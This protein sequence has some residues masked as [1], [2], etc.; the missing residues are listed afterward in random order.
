MR[1]SLVLQLIE[2]I[3]H[4]AEHKS[5]HRLERRERDRKKDIIISRPFAHLLLASTKKNISIWC[6]VVCAFFPV[7]SLSPF[8]CLST[9]VPHDHFRLLNS[10]AHFVPCYVRCATKATAYWTNNQCEEEER[11]RR[12]SKIIFM[13]VLF[14]PFFSFFAS[15]IITWLVDPASI[16]LL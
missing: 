6:C 2:T 10:W 7:F 13:A 11:E 8:F 16:H 3:N 4:L 15:N 5:P 12:R 9:F 1:L 14:G